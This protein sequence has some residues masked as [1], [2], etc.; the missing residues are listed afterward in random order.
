MRITFIANW[1]PVEHLTMC[2]FSQ[3]NNLVKGFCVNLPMSSGCGKNGNRLTAL[4][5]C[6]VFQHWCCLFLEPLL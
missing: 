5:L 3:L 6:R 1:N 4:S 2:A